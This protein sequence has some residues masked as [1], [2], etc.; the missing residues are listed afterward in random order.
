MV[1]FE[2]A[3]PQDEH[4]TDQ[5]LPELEEN[6]YPE[7][8]DECG[9][10]QWVTGGQGHYNGQY[11]CYTLSLNCENCGDYDVECV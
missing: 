9:G 5:H 7:P 4:W 1:T 11:Q 6:E 2:L 10:R 3:E 8:C